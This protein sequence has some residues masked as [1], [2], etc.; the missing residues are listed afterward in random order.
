MKR[1]DRCAGKIRAVPVHATAGSATLGSST[2]SVELHGPG[3]LQKAVSMAQDRTPHPPLATEEHTGLLTGATTDPATAPPAAPSQ[4]VS[5]PAPVDNA[6]RISRPP[7]ELTEFLELD[8]V[9][10]VRPFP[11]LLKHPLAAAGWCL[12]LLFGLASLLFVLSVI[13]AV[14][15]VNFLALGYLLEAEGQV[16]RTGKLRAGF[17]LLGLAPRIGSIVLG[18][19]LFVFPL[20]MLAAAAA[21]AR[22]ID[23]TG[24]A[25]RT[26]QTIT[27]LSALL[28]TVHLCLALA[29]GGSLS[30][31]FRPVRNARW[32]LERLRSHSYWSHAEWNVREF[33]TRLRLRHHFWLGL[34]GYFG[35]LIWL[36]LPTGLLTVLKQTGRPGQAIVTVLG[37]LLLAVVLGW[38]P[39]LQARFAASGRL[40]DMF[41]LRAVRQEIRRVPL[42]F[43]LTVIS[44]FP[45]AIVLYLA[46][47]RLPPADA[48]WLITP[49]FILTIYP[50]RLVAG[51]AW[52]RSQQKTAPARRILR[53]PGRLVTFPLLALFVFL[54][55]F[56]QFIGEHGQAVLFEHHAFL[57]PVPFQ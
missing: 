19:T 39:F 53:W 50:G 40:R 47:V 15:V 41:E 21:D 17:P 9:D 31:F 8:E 56:T 52:Y 45:L 28:V 36:L 6:P 30:C 23:P 37:G 57:L 42:A 49:I 13:A 18:V 14:P 24:T 11:H 29:R 16:A 55:F 32:L 54:L 22:L 4:D 33:F 51:W 1:P 48:A 46:K 43:L 25:A 20:R 38:L 3:N 2:V 44:V 12:R 7:A 5:A 35:G 26:W 27:L 10:R 34:R